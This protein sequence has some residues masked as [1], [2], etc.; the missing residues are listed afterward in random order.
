[1]DKSEAPL[2]AEPPKQQFLQTVSRIRHF[3]NKREPKLT[4]KV[5]YLAASCDLM[6]SG[7]IERIRK[8]KE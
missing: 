4:D 3:S 8:A 1:V 5:V 6:H 2:K 7:V